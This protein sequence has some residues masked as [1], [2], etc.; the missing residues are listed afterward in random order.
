MAS[1]NDLPWDEVTPDYEPLLQQR[2]QALGSRASRETPLVLYARLVRVAAATPRCR[3]RSTATTGPTTYVMHPRK[4][5]RKAT[6]SATA[7]ATPSV[8]LVAQNLDLTTMM[9]KGVGHVAA[10]WYVP[11][12]GTTCSATTAPDT[13]SRI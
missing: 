7:R 2:L 4:H 12:S 6:N 5:W 10:A 13:T 9:R 3:S 8:M 11:R 1:A